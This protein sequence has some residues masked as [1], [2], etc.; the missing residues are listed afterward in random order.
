MLLKGTGVHFTES[1]EFSGARNTSSQ[2]ISMLAKLPPPPPIWRRKVIIQTICCNIHYSLQADFLLRPLTLPYFIFLCNETIKDILGVIT[3]SLTFLVWNLSYYLI[4]SCY[5]VELTVA[6][7]YH[8]ARFQQL[9]WWVYYLNRNKWWAT[10]KISCNA[11]VKAKKTI[12]HNTEKVWHIFR[13]LGGYKGRRKLDKFF[14]QRQ[15]CINRH[16]EVSCWKTHRQE[17]M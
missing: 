6:K 8:V 15:N 4:C 9:L 13:A 17:R 5:H 3:F 12:K 2:Q 7:N 10:I 11:N 16:K 14:I 1:V